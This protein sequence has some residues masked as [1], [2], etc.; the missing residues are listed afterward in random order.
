MSTFSEQS[1]RKL[2]AS[3]FSKQSR[4]FDNLYGP[5][6]TIN[7]K[8]GRVRNHTMN[9]LKE[10]GNILELNSGTGEDAIF[11]AKLGHRVH[12]TD[13][14]AGMQNALKEKI[15]HDNL[16]QYITTELCSFTEL[17]K[18]Q[19]NGPFDYIFSNF[20]G[21]NCTNELAKVLSSFD[22]LLKPKGIITLVLMPKFCLWE[23]LL[24]FKGR[25]KIAT[26]RWFSKNGTKAHIEG[27]YFTCWYYNPSF[28]IRNLGPGF[29]LL[30]LEGLCTIVPPSYI[31][32][33][34]E[35]YPKSWRFLKKCEDLLKSKLPWKFIGDYYIISLQ[36]NC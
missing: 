21:L 12:A 26:R 13:I 35:K 10:Q 7:Y 5:N 1:N 31:E 15:K 6:S 22:A 11:Y 36:K 33:F 18:L 19:N 20:A 29:I 25:I 4:L 17:E 8:R 24:L 14:S 16:G 34:V 2:V 23:S 30:N 3:A 9:Y 28:I 32:D 27:I